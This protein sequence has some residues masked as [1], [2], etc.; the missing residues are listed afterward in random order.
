MPQ[1]IVTPF[2]GRWIRDWQQADDP[3][4]QPTQLLVGMVMTV[5]IGSLVFEWVG[6]VLG[7]SLRR[8]YRKETLFT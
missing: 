6:V 3:R 4:M 1:T 2:I 8:K 7:P 5:A